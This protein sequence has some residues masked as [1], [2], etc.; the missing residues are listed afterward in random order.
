VYG[1]LISIKDENYKY[2]LIIDSEGLM[3]SE[4][5]DPIFDNKIVLFILA[6]SNIVLIN[7]KGDIHQPMKN[8][9]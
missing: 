2:I 8:L 5:N 4:K 1:S 3:N 7:I 9:L 6:I